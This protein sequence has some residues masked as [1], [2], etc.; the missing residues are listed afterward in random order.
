MRSS[1]RLRAY[2]QRD[3]LVEYKKEGLKL[4]KEMEIATRE[5]ILRILP[6]IAGGAFVQEEKALKDTQKKM[7]LVSGG[8]E[9]GSVSKIAGDAGAFAKVGR[10]DDCPCGAKK[11]DGTPKKYKHCHGA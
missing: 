7:A 8:D 9:S 2:G 4:F 5:Q 1:V 11:D 3:P 10:N 6:N